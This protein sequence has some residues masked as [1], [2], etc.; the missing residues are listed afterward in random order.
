MLRSSRSKSVIVIGLALLA[1]APPAQAGQPVTLTLNPPPPPFQTCRLV[2]S[3]T[4][5]AGERTIELNDD[6]GAVCGD[7]SDSFDIVI[8]GTLDQLARRTYDA[9]GNMARRFIQDTYR[10]GRFANRV[11]GAS[12]PFTGHDTV[13]DLL[14]TPADFNTATET[15]NGEFIVT[16]PHGGVIYLSAGTN[17]TAVADGTLDF[18]AGPGIV[19][20]WFVNGGPMEAP[21]ELCAALDSS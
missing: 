18:Q 5:C 3:G 12:V 19:S 8:S 20:E 6:T 2:G 14:A 21:S 15:I 16:L 13:A 11:T 4:I 10:S 17:R 9:A 7:G 1:L